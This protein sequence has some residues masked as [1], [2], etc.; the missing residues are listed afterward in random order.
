MHANRRLHTI[1]YQ[2]SDRLCSVT[3]AIAA[4]AIAS[5]T[6]GAD[7]APGHSREWLTDHNDRAHQHGQTTYGQN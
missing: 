5:A 2:L 6:A 4:S 1:N 3:A 7:V